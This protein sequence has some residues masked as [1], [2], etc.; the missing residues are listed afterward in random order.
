M[1]SFLFKYFC[2][3]TLTVTSALNAEEND[4][5]DLTFY[6]SFLHT[7]TVPNALFFFNDIEQY[8]SFE[9]RRAIR[10]HDIDIVVLA[11]NGGSVW[12]GLNMAGIIHDKGIATY[13]PQLP[14]ELGCYSACSFMFFGGKIRQADGILAVH[15]AGAYGSERDKAK[16]KVSE[17][18]QNTQFTVSEIIGFLNEFET[19]PWVF[20]KM[21]RSREFYYFDNEEKDRLAARTEDISPDNLH[22][23]NAFVSSFLK[24]LDDL[25]EEKRQIDEVKTE[26]EPEKLKL[27][28][29]NKTAETELKAPTG[30]QDTEQPTPRKK[31]KTKANEADKLRLVVTKIQKLLNDAGCNAGIPDGIWGQ[32]TQAAA[33]LFAK[34]AKLPTTKTQLMS[35]KFVEALKKA[36]P[37][38]C[39]NVKPIVSGYHSSGWYPSYQFS[40]TRAPNM[41]GRMLL[42]LNSNPSSLQYNILYSSGQNLSGQ[43]TNI[44]N[45]TA[46]FG[47]GINDKRPPR[48]K[49]ARS[50]N[51]KVK[52]FSFW[53]FGSGRCTFTGVQ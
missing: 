25:A 16:A 23:I 47:R 11:S 26:V 19:P 1:F 43:I 15:Q 41:N 37:S 33:L 51:G 28:D 12:E 21:F 9:L 48:M 14:E 17:T 30:T 46:S 45:E 39:K 50:S 32:K 38:F 6:G 13:V 10:N 49:L 40:C 8:D 7:G 29:P 36:P 34:I 18:Q 2:L 27:E 44:K 22:E 42:N 5:F 35:D 31:E 3:I 20:E 24:Y 4:L 52:S 53:M